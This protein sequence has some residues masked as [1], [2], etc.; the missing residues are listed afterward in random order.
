MP[1]FQ[2][3]VF[4]RQGMYFPAHIQENR[5]ENAAAYHPALDRGVLSP[6]TAMRGPVVSRSW[7]T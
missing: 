5:D 4:M 3:P 2:H 7:E 1:K 6:R